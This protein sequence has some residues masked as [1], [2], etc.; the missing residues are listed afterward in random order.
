MV[1]GTVL[2]LVAA[3]VF[4]LAHAAD[5][6]HTVWTAFYRGSFGPATPAQGYLIAILFTLF[7]LILFGLFL[8]SR[9]V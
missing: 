4:S 5:L 1:F 6:R 8:F 3:R 9:R 2:L 7:A